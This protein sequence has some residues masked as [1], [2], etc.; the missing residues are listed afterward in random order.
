VERMAQRAN[1]EVQDGGTRQRKNSTLL[2]AIAGPK[3]SRVTP[4]VRPA[5]G[6]RSAARTTRMRL[7]S[8]V[9]S[10]M[11]AAVGTPKAAASADTVGD[12]AVRSMSEVT[13]LPG[14]VAL[15]SS[16]SRLRALQEAGGDRWLDFVIGVRLRAETNR[17][18]WRSAMKQQ[19]VENRSS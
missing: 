15:S 5:T 18:N 16:S 13:L 1:A 14:A 8:D 7:L 4:E 19:D 2:P 12:F 9:V 6:I 11:R 10:L 3:L 17:T